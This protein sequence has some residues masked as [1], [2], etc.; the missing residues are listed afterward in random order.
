MPL[1]RPRGY[2]EIRETPAY[3]A[4]TA[5][6]WDELEGTLDLARS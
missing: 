5:R 2:R 4:L 1:A 3:G 6:L